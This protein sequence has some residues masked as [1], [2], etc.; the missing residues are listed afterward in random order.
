MLL[1]TIFF[2][3]LVEILGGPCPESGSSRLNPSFVG[4]TT[5][6]Y[7]PRPNNWY[8]VFQTSSEDLSG[9]VQ[10][11]YQV[12]HEPTGTALYQL[13]LVECEIKLIC[14]TLLGMEMPST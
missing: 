1:W 6:S 14:V 2:Y 10:T 13:R 7:N 11:L 4:F 12:Y 3:L 9:I 5:S 8:V